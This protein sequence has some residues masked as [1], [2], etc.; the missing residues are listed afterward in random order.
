MGI[1]LDVLCQWLIL[2]VSHPGAT[3]VVGPVLIAVSYSMVRALANRV[4]RHMLY[5]G[6][7]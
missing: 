1:L 7:R 5:E 2:G 6:R 4:T 3:L